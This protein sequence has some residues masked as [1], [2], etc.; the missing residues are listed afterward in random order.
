MYEQA[1]G[2]RDENG[3]RSYLMREPI[4]LRISRKI[5]GYFRKK[6]LS[7]YGVGYLVDCPQGL[8][9]VDPS[10]FWITR[11]LLKN[12]ENDREAIRFLSTLINRDSFVCFVGAHIGTLLVPLADKVTRVVAYEAD[13]SNFGYLGYNVRLNNI[14]NTTIH[15]LAVGDRNGVEVAIQHELS[16]TGHS[17][18]K[19]E[20][21][22]VR[23]PMV[24]LDQHLGDDSKIRLVVMDIEGAEVHAIRGMSSVLSHVEYLYTEFCPRHLASFGESS[25]SFVEALSPHF[26]HMYICGD[27]LQT[28]K[29]RR[30]VDF[31][32]NLPAKKNDLY[33]LLFTNQNVGL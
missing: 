30:W 33:N 6:A 8:F 2:K 31:V 3:L 24:T 12:G 28:F 5:R 15:N 25:A 14:S 29:N 9:V 10:D 1:D 19:F 7:R 23:V 26:A 20:G 16:N 17:S 21:D 11:S 4:Q 27:N 18:I 32:K 22:G 13:P